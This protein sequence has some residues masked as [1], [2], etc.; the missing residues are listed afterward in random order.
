MAALISTPLDAT[1]IVNPAFLVTSDQVNQLRFNIRSLLKINPIFKLQTVN[2][3]LI[4]FCIS[5]NFTILL[6]YFCSFI[7]WDQHV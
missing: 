4:I 7:F 5:Y 6:Y 1:A 2:W 3:H